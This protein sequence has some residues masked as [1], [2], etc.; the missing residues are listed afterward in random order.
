M[1]LLGFTNVRIAEVIGVHRRTLEVWT[2]MHEGLRILLQ[3][4]RD[5]ADAKVAAGLFRRAKGYTYANKRAIVVSDGPAKGSH[6]EMVEEI[7]HVPPDPN[8]AALWLSNRHPDLW[9]LR[10]GA[11][12]FDP[13]DPVKIIGGLPKALP[14]AGDAAD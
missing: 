6:V 8:A 4:G 3:D 9:K 12:D 13:K 7:I 11:D 5:F 10:R 2:K 1:A 14:P